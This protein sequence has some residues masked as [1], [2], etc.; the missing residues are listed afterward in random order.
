LL[1]GR[2]IRK[3]GKRQSTGSQNT[4]I[5][6]TKAVRAIMRLKIN[7]GVKKPLLSRCIWLIT[8]ANEKYRLRFRSE[9][10]LGAAKKELRH[11]HVFPR[12]DLIR[13][14]MRSTSS[15]KRI[16][17]KAVACVVTEDEHRR[18]DRVSRENPRLEGWKRY[19]VAG[20][21]VYDVQRN[22]WINSKRQLR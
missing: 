19:K 18:L 12:R 17:K 21:R 13:A 1:R 5:D 4:V 11:E 14:L 7:P 22:A 16:L 10:A 15:V 20:I 9:E 2:R 3:R 6:A 8:E